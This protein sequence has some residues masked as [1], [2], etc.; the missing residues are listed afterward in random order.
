MLKEGLE[1]LKNAEF[2]KA[3]MF[4]KEHYEKYNDFESYYYMVNID[5]FNLSTKNNVE[6]YQMFKVMHKK[7][8]K[9]YLKKYI[10]QLSTLAFDL[11]DYNYCIDILLLG[12]KRNI[13]DNKLSP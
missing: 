10:F 11:E 2:E 3:Y 12:E 7:A 4:F 1:H 6:Y 8:P 9:K 5:Y 13:L